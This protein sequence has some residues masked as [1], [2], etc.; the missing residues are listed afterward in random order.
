MADILYSIGLCHHSVSDRPKRNPINNPMAIFT[1]MGIQLVQRVGSLFIS[2]DNH[3]TLMIMGE[4]GRYED[5][6]NR[7]FLHSISL[8]RGSR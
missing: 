1:V 8:S 4:F 3:I 7:I 5:N 2:D 6:F